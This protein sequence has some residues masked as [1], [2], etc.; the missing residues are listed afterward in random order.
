M[1]FKRPSI[2]LAVLSCFALFAAGP[3]VGGEKAPKT[4]TVKRGP[5]GEVVK[6]KGNIA[7]AV[8]ER[9]AV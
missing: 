9:V 1:S 2:A 6:A 8:F 4:A 3:A 5:L 7:P